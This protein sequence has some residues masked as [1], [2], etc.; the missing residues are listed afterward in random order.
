MDEDNRTF[1]DV[2][3]QPTISNEELL[4]LLNS[5]SHLIEISFMFTPKTKEEKQQVLNEIAT[6]WLSISL[7][8]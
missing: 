1:D 2:I 8:K 5:K 7:T 4:S 6:C 3:L